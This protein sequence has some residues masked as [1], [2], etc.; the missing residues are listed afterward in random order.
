[1]NMIS[2]YFN[3]NRT[4]SNSSQL[5]H[6]P[7]EQSNFVESRKIPFG[8]PQ[9]IPDS[10]K[11]A[12]PT[13]KTRNALDG[14]KKI[15]TEGFSSRSEAAA[16]Q[17]NTLTWKLSEIKRLSRTY[18][19]PQLVDDALNILL[20]VMTD[21]RLESVID[22]ILEKL[23]NNTNPLAEA[24]LQY[25]EFMDSN[26]KKTA[27]E[28]PLHNHHVEH[29]P[30][31]VVT[32]LTQIELLLEPHYHPNDVWEAIEDLMRKFTMTGEDS[33]LDAALADYQMKYQKR[34]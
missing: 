7:H 1:M 28:K 10:Q 14:T 29:L 15:L 25:S 30:E 22:D 13:E 34:G 2:G 21:N 5:G 18:F 12:S 17:G 19:Q 27:K 6:G 3:S 8:N 31:G 24:F 26:L 33:V 32:K 23:R 20:L 16:K 11:N 9:Y 4:S